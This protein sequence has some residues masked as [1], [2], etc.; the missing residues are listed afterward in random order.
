M[1]ECTKVQYK[2]QSLGTS[3]GGVF[4]DY[5]SN[6]K[7]EIF[8]FHSPRIKTLLKYIKNKLFSLS[9]RSR[10]AHQK[11]LYR[12]IPQKTNKKQNQ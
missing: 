11:L 3:R 8:K 2:I 4:L 6:Q 12:V 5:A 9:D 10:S 1:R 7:L